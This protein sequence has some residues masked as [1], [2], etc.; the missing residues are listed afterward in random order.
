MEIAYIHTKFSRIVLSCTNLIFNFHKT[1]FL[2]CYWQGGPGSCFYVCGGSNTSV[3]KWYLCFIF[4]QILPWREHVI[5][6]LTIYQDCLLGDEKKK[7][8]IRNVHSIVLGLEFHFHTASQVEPG[9]GRIEACIIFRDP[10]KKSN[11]KLSYFPRFYRNIGWYEHIARASAWELVH[12]KLR[13]LLFRGRCALC[14]ALNL[15]MII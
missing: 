12:F 4:L 14:S 5:N 2:A 13:K 11:I 10:V 9:F 8:V 6:L 15:E 1:M 3:G 7:S